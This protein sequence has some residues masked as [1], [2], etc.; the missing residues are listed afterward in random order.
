M[1]LVTAHFD[2]CA[3]QT[4]FQRDHRRHGV[5]YSSAFPAAPAFD[6]PRLD[7]L[8]GNDNAVRAAC[9]ERAAA[10]SGDL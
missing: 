2:G 1:Q 9:L 8:S 7:V 6:R 5:G 3:R 4:G 10:F